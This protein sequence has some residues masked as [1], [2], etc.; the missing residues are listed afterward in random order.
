MDKK[1][2][3][4][5][6]VAIFLVMLLLPHPNTGAVKASIAKLTDNATKKPIVDPQIYE[7]DE[8]EFTVILWLKNKESM[9]DALQYLREHDANIL[10]KYNL[11]PA[12][13]MKTSKDAISRISDL[14]GLVG[15][16]Y[17]R[18]YHLLA[19]KPVMGIRTSTLE[20]SKAIGA[21][22][23]WANG[24]KGASIKIGIID[25][26]VDPNHPDL[27]GKVIAMESF[28]KK[29][30][31]YDVDDTDPTDGYIGVWHGT[32][33][34]GVAAGAGKGDPNLG[35][36]VAPEALIISAKVFPSGSE[37]YATLAGIIA[38]IEWCVSQGA[39]VINMS[40]GGGASYF[41]PVNLAVKAAVEAGTTVVVA[42]G[43]EGDNGFRTMSV[44]SPAFSPYA[45]SVAAADINGTMI[46]V[47]YSSIGPTILMT[48]KPDIT[49][50]TGVAAPIS[51]KSRETPPYG[52][53]AEGTSF[54]SPHIAGAAALIAQYLKNAGIDKKYWPAIIKY[55]LMKT[56]RPIIYG[57]TEYYELWAGAGFVDLE[58][59]YDFLEATIGATSTIPERIFVMPMRVPTGKSNEDVFFPYAKKL[60]QGMRLEFNFTIIAT[61]NTTVQI[62]LVGNISDVINLYSPTTIDVISPATLWEFNATLS[63]TSEGY[64][65]GWI[66]FSTE[67]DTFNVSMEF[68]LVRPKMRWLFDLKHTSW[69]VDFKYGQYKNFYLLLESNNISVEHWYFSWQHLTLEILSRYDVV[70]LP[71]AASYYEV[72]DKAGFVTGIHTAKF[73]SEEIDAFVTYVKN[74]GNLIL[75]GMTPDSNN[76]TE[77]SRLSKNFGVEF[78][79]NMLTPP[80]ETVKAETIGDHLLTR[81]V[82]AIPFYG[83][84]LKVKEAGMAIAQYR[85]SPVAAVCALERGGFVLAIATNFLFDNWAFGGLYPVSTKEVRQFVTNIVDLVTSQ[86][87]MTFTISPE[88]V[89]MGEEISIKVNTTLASI[90][91]HITDYIGKVDLQFTTTD[92]SWTAS[93]TTRVAGDTSIFVKGTLDNGYSIHRASFITI[94]KSENNPPQIIPQYDNESTIYYSKGNLTIVI[95][96]KDDYGILYNKKFVK[97]NTNITE[98]IIEVLETNKTT[99]VLKIIVP[100]SIVSDLLS[101]KKSFSIQ[102]SIEAKDLNLN[103]LE[104]DYLFY[105]AKKGIEISP[106]IVAIIIGV[107]LIALIV[108]VLKLRKK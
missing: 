104:E 79:Q 38:A 11:F 1:F 36:G 35:T 28:V 97:I 9:R 89:K 30:Y 4:T 67:A 5:L 18:R 71:D 48:A 40:L 21:D 3:R 65:R 96:I 61:V 64:Y 22:T 29:E 26:G 37:T 15:I 42:A 90:E 51:T 107:V 80:G 92:T 75:I 44:G 86:K 63:D 73:T 102:L 81:D 49:A 24:Y 62:Q 45:I 76:M 41:D 91:G 72:F 83:V 33:V 23:F 69:T 103:K 87:E 58:A 12:I 99:I 101:S 2:L 70:F 93:H 78:T 108:V 50:P 57:D 68:Y 84:A 98:T 85:N 47:G 19:T 13:V 53:P 100:E 60:F 59:A 52:D 105:V 39:D 20:S 54:S 88:T 43:N 17:N 82:T 27:E 6:V 25:T 32:R 14:P 55:V 56:A 46:R 16:F 77:L 10:H 106:I 74:G 31:G 34:A 8:K 94:E 7:T 66:I 95:A